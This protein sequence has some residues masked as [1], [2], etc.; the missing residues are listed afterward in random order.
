M[1]LTGVLVLYLAFRAKQLVCDFFLQTGWMATSKVLPFG[2]GGGKALAAHA[3]IHA[4]GTLL[5]TLVFAPALWWLSPLDFVVH[6]AVDKLKG[7]ITTAK[8]WG[9]KDSA[10]WW[11][12]GVDQEM[13]NLTHLFYIVLIAL[14]AGVKLG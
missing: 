12:F 2:Q 10:F 7:M 9:Y 14:H 5:L 13:H 3:G 1:S 6:G 11:A 8:G 4:L